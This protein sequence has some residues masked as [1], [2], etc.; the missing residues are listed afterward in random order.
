MIGLAKYK[1]G[2][3]PEG[4][5]LDYTTYANSGDSMSQWLC[6]SLINSPTNSSIITRFHLL[7]PLNCGPKKNS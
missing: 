4:K 1:S 3:N 6:G 5:S 7:A 2:G